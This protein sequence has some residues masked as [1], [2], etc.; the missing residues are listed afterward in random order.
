M[1]ARRDPYNL[2]MLVDE[3]VDDLV[4]DGWVL[5]DETEKV[6]ASVVTI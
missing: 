2:A 5:G 4:D 6:N 3:M 1:G